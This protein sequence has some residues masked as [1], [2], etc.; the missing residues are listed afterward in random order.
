MIFS[1][2]SILILVMGLFLPGRFNTDLLLAD[3][4]CR[5]QIRSSMNSLGNDWPLFWGVEAISGYGYRSDARLANFN[6]SQALA[7]NPA[8]FRVYIESGYKW[9]SKDFNE[10]DRNTVQQGRFGV[11]AMKFSY[12]NDPI[13]MTAGLFEASVQNSFILDE[14]VIGI[15]LKSSLLGRP[16]QLIGGTVLKNF[17]R[18]GASC[19]VSHLLKI[20]GSQPGALLGNKMGQMNFAALSWRLL[21]VPISAPHDQEF[22]DEFTTPESTDLASEKIQLEY[23]NL[24]AYGDFGQWIDTLHLLGGWSTALKLPGITRFS[25]ESW[26]QI[27]SNHLNSI[28]KIQVQKDLGWQHSSIS[29]AYYTFWGDQVT[30]RR[31]PSFS[32]LFLGE[33]AQLDLINAPLLVFKMTIPI[34]SLKSS[35]RFDYVHQIEQDQSRE[36]DLVIS[37]RFPGNL[38]A[39]F[40]LSHLSRQSLDDSYWLTRMELHWTF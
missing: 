22:Q 5:S 38:L 2:F 39:Y 8:H 19:G 36:V 26:I 27:Q 30:S 25:A 12:V 14:R 16:W 15:D 40:W 11:R 35:I 7:F 17:A 31:S 4:D 9:Y 32:N 21:P 10:P 24:Q 29:G 13:E 18:H 37:R 1:R 34:Q 33:M 3:E 23:L 20:S 28:H 6:L